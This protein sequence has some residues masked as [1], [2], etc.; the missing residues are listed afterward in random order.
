MSEV[1]TFSVAQAAK[2]LP[3]V[4]DIVSD[5]LKTGQAIRDLSVETDKPEDNP[6]INRLMDVLDE[7]FD[8][9]ESIGCFY[10]DWNFTEGLVDFP[11]KISGR[12]VMLCWRSDEENIR[13]YHEAEA[14]YAG[15]RL[16]PKDLLEE[17]I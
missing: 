7:L 16:I 2:T 9:I 15:R 6:E 3:L 5:I 14:G 13:Y 8:E 12:D 1:K 4:R 11:A 17:P 10:K